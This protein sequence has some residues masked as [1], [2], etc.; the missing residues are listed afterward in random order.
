MKTLHASVN[1]YS[2]ADF[3]VSLLLTGILI[4]ASVTVQQKMQ[5]KSSLNVW[6]CHKKNHWPQKITQAC[7]FWAVF[8]QM[9]TFAGYPDE[10]QLFHFSSDWKCVFFLSF[11]WRWLSLLWECQLDA[12]HLLVNRVVHRV[13][14][15]T[16]LAGELSWSVSGDYDHVIVVKDGVKKCYRERNAECSDA[17]RDG[18]KLGV[19]PTRSYFSDKT[20]THTNTHT[21]SDTF[22]LREKGSVLQP[23]AQMQFVFIWALQCCSNNLR[24]S[25]KSIYST[26]PNSWIQVFPLLSWPQ[27]YKSQHVGVQT[28]STNIWDRSHEVLGYVKSQSGVEVA[29]FLQSTTTDLQASQLAQEFP[30]PSSCT[31]VLHHQRQRKVSDAVM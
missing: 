20:H 3:I 18:Y 5:N 21:L 13:R 1:Y 4:W 8:C 30:R 17:E 10:I 25:S 27:V 16:G 7:S 31:Q 23:W 12:W 14:C 9:D 29:N 26:H 2:I 15:A 24:Y 11:S 22:L 6:W 28:A 19:F